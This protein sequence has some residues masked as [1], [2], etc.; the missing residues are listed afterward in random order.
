MKIRLTS[1]L[2]DQCLRI[3]IEGEG[4]NDERSNYQST[5]FHQEQPSKGLRSALHCL[6]ND[7]YLDVKLTVDQCSASPYRV[8][9]LTKDSTKKQACL[10]DSRKTLL[11]STL[12]PSALDRRNEPSVLS[13]VC[14]DNR[15]R[16]SCRKRE[17]DSP[18][19]HRACSVAAAHFLGVV[20]RPSCKTSVHRPI[21]ALPKVI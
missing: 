15:R 11:S 7:S 5:D 8:N 18:V 13:M 10:F 6:I 17:V 20:R 16:T 4:E 9:Q 2:S 14:L 19:E 3:E 1:I 12:T 21:R